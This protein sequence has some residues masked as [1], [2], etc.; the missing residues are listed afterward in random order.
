MHVAFAPTHDIIK[1]QTNTQTRQYDV[2]QPQQK[3]SITYQAYIAIVNIYVTWSDS[4]A[5]CV[6]T[7]SNHVADIRVELFLFA[8]R[9]PK[10]Y[11]IP[12]MYADIRIYIS[13]RSFAG[14]CNNG[15]R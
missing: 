14:R 6:F 10:I 15:I 1:K 5:A 11:F 7:R 8:R 2:K 13:S 4:K 9:W 3:C 12:C